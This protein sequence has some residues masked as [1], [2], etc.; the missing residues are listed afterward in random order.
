MATFKSFSFFNLGQRGKKSTQC[1]IAVFCVAGCL[2]ANAFNV[3]ILLHK[4]LNMV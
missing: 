3:D 4:I 2:D 1:N